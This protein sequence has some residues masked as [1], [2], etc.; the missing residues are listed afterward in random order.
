MASLKKSPPANLRPRHEPPTLEE[1]LFAAEGFIDE[2]DQQIEF[3]AELMDLPVEDVRVQAEAFFKAQANRVIVEGARKPQSVVV[4][5]RS[6]AP[7]AI[8]RKSPSFT[9][10][11]KNATPAFSFER[12]PM[13]SK[14]VVETRKRVITLPR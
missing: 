10:E 4:E 12:K 14:F 11:R 2:R 8:D 5:T 9:V 3:A 6:S 13:G 7:F 1:A